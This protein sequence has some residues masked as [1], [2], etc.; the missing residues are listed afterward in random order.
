MEFITQHLIWRSMIDDLSIDWDMGHRG[1]GS[2][3]SHRNIYGKSAQ[4]RRIP[5]PMIKWFDDDPMNQ[6]ADDPTNTQIINHRCTNSIAASAAQ[7][8]LMTAPSMVAGRPVSIQSPASSRPGTP[9]LV[10]GRA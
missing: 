4:R 8:P 2:S 7:W 10:A 6:C 3:L 5:N 9:V 1:I